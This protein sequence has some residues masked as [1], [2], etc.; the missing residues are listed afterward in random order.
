M[1]VIVP[2]IFTNPNTKPPFPS[3][4]AATQYNPGDCVFYGGQNFI[5]GGVGTLPINKR[6]DLNQITSSGNGIFSEASTGVPANPNGGC[7]MN[8]TLASPPAMPYSPLPQVPYSNGAAVMY[9]PGSYSYWKANNPEVFNQTPAL[10]VS[11][12]PNNI[13]TGIVRSQRAT[14]AFLPSPTWTNFTNDKTG[15]P[16]PFFPSA[17]S[18]TI[19]SPPTTGVQGPTQYWAKSAPLSGQPSVAQ[20]QLA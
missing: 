2:N 16:I 6:P 19:V 4:N 11:A 17:G 10:T 20:A 3:W 14:N 12:Q 7:W 8:L 5:A 13:S 15:V 9:P 1:S 18:T